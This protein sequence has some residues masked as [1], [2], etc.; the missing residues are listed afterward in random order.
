M[1]A[2][3]PVTRRAL[4]RP[5]HRSVD[6]NSSLC[7]DFVPAR[8]T[9][10][11]ELVLPVCCPKSPGCALSE[12]ARCLFAGTLRDGSDGTRTRDLRRD[13][14][15]RPPRRPPTNSP[16][17]LHLQGS[18]LLESGCH[19]MVEPIVQPTFGPR[20]GHEI[21]SSETT[22]ASGEGIFSF[23]RVLQKAKPLRWVSTGCQRD[24]VVR[25][26]SNES[27]LRAGTRSAERRAHPRRLTPSISRSQAR[28][29]ARAPVR[30][31]PAAYDAA[32]EAAPRPHGWRRAQ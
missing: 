27:T 23:W 21:L 29:G 13:R 19:G 2:Q 25:S 4:V 22:A 20:A 6:R 3:A 12:N 32:V 26:H 17:R 10:E 11:P 8:V 9:C 28:V 15:S 7:R 16:E 1:P 31:R 18:L 30:R 14:P 24:G 5:R